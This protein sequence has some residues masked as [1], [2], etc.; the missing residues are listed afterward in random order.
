[1]T[2]L[3]KIFAKAAEIAQKLPDNLQEAAFN[4][5]LD[6]LLAGPQQD[7]DT[8]K[9]RTRRQKKGTK[10]KSNTTD[11][12]SYDFTDSIDRAKYPDIGATDRLADRAL[13]VLQLANDDHGTDG[14]T[15]SQIAEIL[16]KKLRLPAKTNAVRMALQRESQTVDV[17]SG[18]NGKN[19]FHIMAPGDDYLANLRSGDIEPRVHR[20]IETAQK[21]AKK[22]TKKKVQKKAVVR[23]KVGSKKK[24]TKKPAKSKSTRL[25][26]K[27]AIGK[28]VEA[29]YFSTQRQISE[30]QEELRHT[31]G[32]LFS[33]QELSPTLLRCV[34]DETLSRSR[35]DSGQYEYS[36]A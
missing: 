10:A 31:R 35:N 11:P 26:P 12:D 14:L 18:P 28:L 22:K 20:N 19:L 21:A 13:K 34:R 30:I 29:G 8:K 23:K 16:T 33:V 15:A 5:A 9:S 24:N 27:A 36:E 3:D 17:R 32:H 7:A 1:M 2:D 25:G 4:R 6:E